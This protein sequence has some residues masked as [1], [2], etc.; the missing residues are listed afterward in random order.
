MAETANSNT[1]PMDEILASIRRIITDEPPPGSL[2][3]SSEAVA[4]S[5]E[6]E[7]ED[8]LELGEAPE[9]EAAVVTAPPAPASP[10][11]AHKALLSE[12]SQAASQRAMAALSGLSIDPNADANTMDGL[13]R[14]MLRPMLKDWLDTH[15]PEMV[16]RL[17]AR[18]VAR[19][20]GR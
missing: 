19:I 4:A 6:D 10:V 9:S 17:V 20:S 3:A 11:T 2:N 1:P 8:V 7:D 12:Q 15:L 5:A 18:E 13:V 14:E 16:E